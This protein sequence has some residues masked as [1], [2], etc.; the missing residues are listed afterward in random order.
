MLGE[1]LPQ[2]RGV[3]IGNRGA[4]LR[5]HACRQVKPGRDR[6]EVPGP[7]ACAGPDQQLVGPCG[8]RRSL[9]QRVDRRAAAVDDALSAD[10]DHG[11]VRQDPEVRRGLR[12]RQKLRVGQ[13]TLHEERLELR[14][15][16]GHGGFTFHLLTVEALPSQVA[17]PR[18]RS[19]PTFS[20]E[21]CAPMENKPAAEPCCLIA[22]LKR[23]FTPFSYPGTNGGMVFSLAGS[24]D[25]R[26]WRSFETRRLAPPM[27]VRMGRPEV[28]G[29]RSK[30]RL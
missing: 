29:A 30:R 14:R 19:L 8:R 16:V 10:L 20:L 15:R 9:H 3:L 25:F 1:Q 11:R 27:S 13:R 22:Q 5:E 12:R 17:S 18:K 6:V 7:G 21:A 4:E 23:P 24:G 2:H 26:S 28:I